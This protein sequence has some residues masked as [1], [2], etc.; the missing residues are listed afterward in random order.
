[1]Y[2][3]KSMSE[4]IPLK[5]FAIHLLHIKRLKTEPLL[6]INFFFM[7][8][9]PEMKTNQIKTKYINQ[10]NISVLIILELVD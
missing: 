5:I 4:V 7:K 3:S 9:L 8:K 2:L 10:L 1:M 6:T